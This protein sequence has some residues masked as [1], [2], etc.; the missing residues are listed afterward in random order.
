MSNA[1]AKLTTRGTYYSNGKVF[2]RLNDNISGNGPVAYAQFDV[3]ETGAG[4]TA[5]NSINK[6]GKVTSVLVNTKG[7]GYSVGNVIEFDESRF[8]KALAEYTA[9][10]GE[11]PGA[12]AAAALLDQSFDMETGKKV[13]ITLKSSA[14]KLIN[15]TGSAS[16]QG[17][18]GAQDV[19]S[20]LL[21]Q[22]KQR[23]ELEDIASYEGNTTSG[24]YV[25]ITASGGEA[26]TKQAV[27][28]VTFNTSENKI[29]RVL[30]NTPG[31]GYQK[32][33]AITLKGGFN[34][35]VALTLSGTFVNV[36]NGVN[37]FDEMPIKAGDKLQMVFTIMSHPDQRDAS[38]D[39]IHI[40]RTALIEIN[41]VNSENTAL[42]P[43]Q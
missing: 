18:R 5:A 23:F 32:G 36:L 35:E 42:T 39:L 12:E 6:I 38:N 2:M 31:E 19:L 8:R 40:S 20:G 41:A 26:V 16:E 30:L 33:D 37:D 43:T 1:T 9:T 13:Q 4:A 11:E 24:T 17:A 7:K 27:F 29:A 15:L 3:T 34:G 14:L 28:D 25:N 21:A 10:V 22:Q